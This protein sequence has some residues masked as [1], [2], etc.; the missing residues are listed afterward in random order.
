MV[1]NMKRGTPRVGAHRFFY[2]VPFDRFQSNTGGIEPG[3]EV[4]VIQ[5][6]GC[7]RN[8]T[9]GMCYVE[10]ITGEFIGLVCINS[11][12]KAKRRKCPGCGHVADHEICN[13]RVE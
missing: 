6:H 8:G 1:F 2:P 7:P 13:G 3:T 4:I 10:H 12:E 5:P 9:M 11:L